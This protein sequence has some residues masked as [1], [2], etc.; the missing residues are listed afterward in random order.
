MHVHAQSIDWQNEIDVAPASFGN[1][2]PRMVSDAQGNPLIVW[3]YNGNLM[4][5]RWES[6]SFS[7]PIALNTDGMKIAQASWMGPDIA[8]HNDM[9]YVVY[10]TLPEGSPNSHIYCRTSKD[11]G[12]TFGSPVQV[13]NINDSLSRFAQVGTD[14]AGNPLVAFMK[15]STTFVEPHWV[16][17]RSSDFGQSFKA[18]AN[19]GNWSSAQA[20]ACDCCPATILGKGEHAIA[21][22]R[23][24]NENIRDIWAGI[25]TDTGVSFNTG[26]NVDNG[27]WQVFSC[28]ASGP[29]AVIINDSLYTVFLSGESGSYRVYLSRTSLSN[30]SWNRTRRIKE[31]YSGINKQNFP[32][33]SNLDGSV[34]IVWLEV[35]STK[36]SLQIAITQNITQNKSFINETVTADNVVNGDVHLFGS[37]VFCCWQ[38]KNSGTVK[39]RQGDFGSLLSSQNLSLTDFNL[40]P[41]PSTGQ[42]Q[43]NTPES[44][45]KIEIYDLAGRLTAQPSA[46][47]I[48]NSVYS[49]D[50]SNLAIGNYVLTVEYANGQTA[51]KKIEL[52]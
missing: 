25:S 12:K 23:D 43:I 1:N 28:P 52:K 33:I 44:I 34:A 19:A 7:T 21:V 40:Y 50:I 26:L 49:I 24:N 32:R 10:K 9:V 31:D 46:Q 16:V 17:C 35:A 5:S 2:Q 29:D 38:D 27:Q 20:E 41:N 45:T 47:R 51:S 4:L 48:S 30:F 15:F 3:G 6:D 13:D 8:A 36:S 22:Y 18:Y 37:K 42:I 14:N 11:G 39:F